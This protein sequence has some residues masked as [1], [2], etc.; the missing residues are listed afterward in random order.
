MAYFE[1]AYCLFSVPLFSFS[2]RKK[3]INPTKIY[4]VDPGIIRA[5]S[6]KNAFESAAKLET[7]VFCHLRRH[8]STIYYYK[9]DTG[10][11]IDFLIEHQGKISLYQACVSLDD[12]T[13]LKREISALQEAMQ[14][15]KVKHAEMITWN[16]PSIHTIVPEGILLT[17]LR[18]FL[19]RTLE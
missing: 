16:T 8:H 17:P 19:L 11:E 15:L 2:H 10:K 1:D 12:P 3:S 9:T 18:S 4:P 13:T 5:Y 6:I 14:A 7:T